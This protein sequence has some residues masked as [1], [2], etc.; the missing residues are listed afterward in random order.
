MLVFKKEIFLV[1]FLSLV[2]GILFIGPPLAIGNYFNNH[3]HEFVLSQ[4]KTYR[5]EVY[6]YVPRA[7][8]IYD[9]HFPPSD[10]FSD[11][12]GPTPLN[13]LPP[14][15]FALFLFFLNGNHLIN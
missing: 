3:D 5:D 8:E 6:T 15:I 7:R 13:A 9:G 2:V 12:P 10:I 14:L 11:K 4:L 1:C